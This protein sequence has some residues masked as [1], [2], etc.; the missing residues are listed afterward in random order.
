MQMQS[1][2]TGKHQQLPSPVT[3]VI[4]FAS[5]AVILLFFAFGYR[6]VQASINAAQ[7]V[8]VNAASYSSPL[9]PGAIAA[10]FGTGLATQVQVAEQIPLPGNL[11]GTSARLTDSRGIAHN[12]QLFF[13]SEGQVNYLVPEA[14]A[15]GAAEIAI[16]SG[17]GTISRGSLQIANCSPA[18]F[19]YTADGKG[20]PVALTTFDGQSYEPVVSTEGVM[21]SIDPGTAWKP[22]YLV[23]FG[24]GLRRAAKVRV[25]IGTAEI[26]PTYAGPQGA[27]AGLDQ[28]NL[29]IPQ[30]VSG[31]VEVRVDADDM[32][33]N[34]VQIRIAGEAL[35]NAPNDL[36]LSD[37]QT[38]IAQ[39]VGK[40]QQAGLR[41]TIAVVDHEGNILGVFKMTGARSDIKLG[42][43]RDF[44]GTAKPARGVPG[45]D[46]LEGQTLPTA[47]A[48]AP[49]NDGAALAAISKAG[50]AAFLSTQGHAFSSRTASFIIQEHL[51]PG[52]DFSSGGPL[53]GVQ[54]S[55]LPCSDINPRLPLGLAGDPG[56]VPIYKN[57][58]AV[59]GVGIEGDGLYGV[60]LNPT[61]KDVP[62]EELIAVAATQNFEAP[63]DIRAEQILVDGVRL[64]FVNAPQTG[65]QAPAFAT[66]DGAVVAPF[67]IRATPASTFT[68]LTLAN[69]PGRVDSRFFPFKASPS[70]AATKLTAAE[71]N[72]IISQAAQ[73]AYR[74]R[75]AIR[76]PL[77]SPVEVNISV[78]DTDGVVLGIF[79]TIDA[80]IFGFDVS[81]Q[82]ARSAA[83]F[84]ST[85]AATR[86]RTAGAF[87][88]GTPLA[89]YNPAK[90]VDAAAAD[91]I[92]LDGTIAF[93]DRGI[94]FLARPFFPDGIQG[95]VQGPFSKPIAEW[96]PFNNGLQIDLA[97]L[98]LVTLLSTGAN[99]AC[100]NVPG[101]QN[102]L[103]I[104][105][106]SV[107]LYKNGVLV[108]AIGISGDGIDQ[109]D[110]IAST[111][112]VGFEAPA[113]RRSDQVFVR[114]VRLPFVKFPRHPNL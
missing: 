90:Y 9:S 1:Q 71:V 36:T 83:L 46:A 13:V 27:L 102:G 80:P 86:L 10:A 60:D 69:V 110:T 106:G 3:A 56:G 113:D 28:I 99:G 51:P 30:G 48:P 35:A 96:S 107:P 7:V 50:T 8:S 45:G 11:A 32:Q 74:M 37:V 34:A 58:T 57:G 105:A 4:S 61:D 100:T 76:R 89:A 31:L 73:Q 79:S 54:F 20:A 38:I 75:A 93:S 53:F 84:S 41:T 62:V 5:F 19:T 26:A 98:A 92:R 85:T 94:G 112:S 2:P 66:L 65:V 91:G 14:A 67:T 18:I 72:T 16:T 33:S 95:T 103:Q 40:S 101:L 25:R 59:G 68:P 47:G 29:A 43:M 39:A 44:K 15:S 22:N 64:P 114:G 111:G 70:T 23:L 12:V 55:Q 63:A 109:D 78:V 52:I 21:R 24:T 17:N 88:V 77:G 81:V 87:L 6:L 104:F 42:A 49:L 97:A 82:K 108:G